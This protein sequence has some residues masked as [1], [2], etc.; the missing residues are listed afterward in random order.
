MDHV[1]HFHFPTT[2]PQPRIG[3]ERQGT[4]QWKEWDR[5]LTIDG[6]RAYH[7][8]NICGTCHFFFSKLENANRTFSATEISKRLEENKELLDAG[9]LSFVSQIFP[10]DDYFVCQIRFKPKLVYPGDKTD[11]FSKECTDLFGVDGYYG[12]PHNPKTPY[13]RDSGISLGEKRLLINFIV[14]L[15]QPGTLDPKRVDYYIERYGKGCVP[16]GLA[17]SILDIEGPAILKEQ[18]GP[19]DTEHWCLAHY[20]IDGHHKIHAAAKLGKECSLLCFISRK[21][22]FGGDNALYTLS[23]APSIVRPE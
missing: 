18:A 3:F 19:A 21:E 1:E 15:H 20:L 8:G 16:G 12:V 14:P 5:F 23:E 9:F 4:P 13:Y 11:Y 10:S 6:K 17:I 7:L 2:A 22:S